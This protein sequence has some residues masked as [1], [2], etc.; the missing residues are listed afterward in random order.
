ML[1]ET[2]FDQ[3]GRRLGSAH[4]AHTGDAGES[5]YQA[6]KRP[7]GA[8]TPSYYFERDEMGSG[9]RVT[10][11]EAIARGATTAAE[12][13]PLLQNCRVLRDAPR[14]QT[15]RG[16]ALGLSRSEVERRLGGRGRDSSGVT[17]Y[18]AIEV[19]RVKGVRATAW[20]S[21]RLRYRAGRVV[22]LAAAAGITN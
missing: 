20:S 6:C 5:R 2:S 10:Q 14:V 18:S 19:R 15:D 22:A 11:F 7:Q 9:E 4:I 1:G 16:V 17:L 13:S 3:L 21:I 12:D 8:D